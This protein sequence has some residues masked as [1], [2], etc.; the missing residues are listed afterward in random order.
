MTWVVFARPGESAEVGQ[1]LP[2]VGPESQQQVS[3][4]SAQQPADR[5]GRLPGLSL[6]LMIECRQRNVMK[7]DLHFF[8]IWFVSVL[9]NIQ[10]IV[11]VLEA[12]LFTYEIFW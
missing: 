2:E 6:M 10:H 9:F 11:K 8:T 1:T 4:R 7:S 3:Q 5:G 12:V